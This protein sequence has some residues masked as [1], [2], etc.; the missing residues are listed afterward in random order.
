MISTVMGIIGSLGLFLFG[1]K[2]MSEGIQK[3]AGEGL[4]KTLNHITANRFVAVITG[5]VITAIIQSSSAT[6]VMVVSFVNAGLLNLTQSIG[7]IMGANVG[8]TIT[9]WIVSLLGFKFKISAMALPIIAIGLPLY[10]SKSSRRRDWGEFF[11]GF[12]ILF[13]GLSFMKDYMPALNANDVSFLTPFTDRGVL[14]LLI[15]IMAGALVTIIVHSSSASMAIIL[16]MA[17]NGILP[18]EAAAAMVM[19]SNIGTTIDAFLASIGAN[20][21]AKRAARVH[22]L[23]NIA[24]VVVISF[25]FKPFI[26]MVNA[27][28]PGT[29]ITTHLAMF[30][31]LFNIL[32]TVIFIGFVNQIAALVKKL[33]PPGKNE[34]GLEKYTL[35]YIESTIQNIP[36]INLMKAKSEVVHMTQVVEDMFD[37]YVD[38][39][40]HPDKKMGSKLDKVKGLEDYSDQMQEE[41]TKFLISCSAENLN[42]IGRKN[43]SA[44]MRIVNELESIG[45]CC[46]SLILLSNRR[47]KKEIPLHKSA[48]DELVPYTKMVQRFLSFIK[49]HM[50]EHLNKEELAE[51]HVLEKKIDKTR[52][53]LK[54]EVRKNLKSGADIKGELLYLD[55]VRHIE[56]IGDYCLN[57]AQALRTVH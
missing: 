22:I 37:I 24:G 31:T 50:N 55:I 1:M 3:A 29:E 44:M 47:Y 52:K 11:I 41:I 4:Q 42:E 36:E 49:D 39:F 13:L 16:T 32:N 34:A 21:N 5:F 17:H 12:G 35:P 40:K 9:G 2:V 7:I 25:V 38:V 23:F 28:V 8:T 56:R 57:I 30:H 46:Y 27:I 54:K 14:S 43:V 19:G 33:V 10:F 51:A 15:F 53:S 26:H 48:I 45:D 6:T 18:F 20:V